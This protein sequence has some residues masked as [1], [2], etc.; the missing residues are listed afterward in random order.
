MSSGGELNLKDYCM[1]AAE[2]APESAMSVQ[3]S[4]DPVA[5][6]APERQAIDAKIMAQV[7]I[8]LAQAVDVKHQAPTAPVFVIKH[9]VQAIVM[10]VPHH[11]GR[12][13]RLQ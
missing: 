7:W 13:V 6:S 8:E 10:E 5:Q 9:D 3:T 4:A 12:K 2:L 11:D 1:D